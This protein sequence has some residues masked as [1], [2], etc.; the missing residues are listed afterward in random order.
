MPDVTRL[1]GQLLNKT[2]RTAWRMRYDEQ[3]QERLV[4]ILEKAIEDVDALRRS[5]SE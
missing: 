1:V 2:Y 5:T 3:Q 4:T